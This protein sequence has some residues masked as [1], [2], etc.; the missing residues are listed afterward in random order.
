MD[1][2]EP[3]KIVVDIKGKKI[4]EADA[5]P[6]E[7]IRPS[8]YNLIKSEFPEWSDESYISREDLKVFRRQ[9]IENL[10]KKEAGELSRIQKEVLKGLLEHESVVKNMNQEIDRKLTAGE[11]MSDRIASFAGSWKF[12]GIFFT[13]LIFWVAVNSFRFIIKPV[14]PFPFILL[15]LMLSCLAAI[16]API[17]LMSQNRKEARDRMRAE[18][19]YKINLK[20]ELEIRLLDEKIDHLTRTQWKRLIEIQQ[21]QIDFMEEGVQKAKKK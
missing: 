6:A 5:V 9:Y 8:V 20:S 18:N 13:L 12:I 4:R 10:V 17:I 2:K 11:R 14:D 15:N 3:E 7:I 21:L 1:R 19:D 16:Q